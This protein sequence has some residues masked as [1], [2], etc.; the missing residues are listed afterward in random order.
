MIKAILVF[1][2]QGKAASSEILRSFCK[3][4]ERLVDCLYRVM[5]QP[6]DEEQQIIREIFHM[7]V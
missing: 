4:L 6:E 5:L 7:V 3:Y 1:N 2:N